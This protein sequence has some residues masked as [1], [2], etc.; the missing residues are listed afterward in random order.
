MKIDGKAII[1]E[2]AELDREVEVGPYAVIG[3]EVKIGKGT[4]ILS[5]AIVEG[6]TSIGENNVIGHHS[7][8]GGLPQ[9]LKYKGENTSLIIG[10][11][12]CIREYV[13]INLGTA[14]GG[15]VTRIGNDS[16]LMAYVHVG[17]DCTLGNNLVIANSCNLAG[18]VSIE[19]WVVLT[20]SVG[21][22]QFC[23]IGKH[24]YIGGHTGVDRNVTP[25]CR[26]FGFRMLARGVNII[27]LRR[28]NFSQDRISA[29]QKAYKIYFQSG[30]EKGRALEEVD[31]LYSEQEDVQY[32]LQFIR[33]VEK[34]GIV[35]YADQS[36]D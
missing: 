6:K 33:N 3:S 4:K 28:R 20:G 8:I 22:S 30:L 7:V 13:T 36:K 9:D 23:R 1:C 25:Y 18:H 12:N 35:Q 21:V 14:D 16:L 11:N 19:D 26:G 27:G 15:G 2:G 31:R 32:F 29:I 10:D 24:A 34:G 17:H 5:H